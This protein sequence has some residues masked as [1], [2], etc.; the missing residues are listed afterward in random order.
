MRKVH[1]HTRNTILG[2][3]DVF[4]P[5][6]SRIMPLQTFRYA[7]CGG[8]N[9][10]LDILLYS[11]SYNFLFQKQVVHVT[12]GVAISAYIAAFL[13]SFTVTF[14]IGFY[15]SRYVVWQETSTRKRIQL[16]RYFLVVMACLVLNY[17]FLKL[18]IESFGWFPTPSKI[19]TSVIVVAF[20]YVSQRHFSFRSVKPQVADS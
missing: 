17:V 3:I 2:I 11:L 7:A 6:F 16:F 13:V 8:G 20:S 1:D 12:G 5:L 18:F 19:A 14:P 9:T 10:L 15:L 4:Y